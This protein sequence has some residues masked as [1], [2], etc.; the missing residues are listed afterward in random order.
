MKI[1]ISFL[2][3]ILLFASCNFDD[4]FKYI[5]NAFQQ[6]VQA[7][8][9]DTLKYIALGDSYTVGTGVTLEERWSEQLVDSLL[10]Y[11]YEFE[12]VVY[13]GQ[14]GWNS[15]ALNNALNQ[16]LLQNTY[17]LVSVM[18]GVNDQF[19]N[20]SKNVLKD[21]LRCILDF[22]IN[23]AGGD[24]SNILMLNIPDWG[25][26]PVGQNFGDTALI[27]ASIKS[28]NVAI[29]EV[30][31]QY[32]LHVSNIFPVSKAAIGDTTMVASDN[33]HFSG[34]MYGLWVDE[35]FPKVLDILP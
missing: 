14:N 20:G 32:G 35:I 26:T 29:E 28:Y 17:D 11:G 13:V 3:I 9:S 8:Q 31:D 24:T 12:P 15:T 5:E 7:N 21:N 18:I 16:G 34:K 33:L 10:L 22:S 25:T 23:L 1:L 4:S 30:A 2:T 6:E 27:A 19:W